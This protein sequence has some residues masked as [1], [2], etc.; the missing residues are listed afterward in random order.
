MMTASGMNEHSI[1]NM[2]F[3]VRIVKSASDLQKVAELRQKAYARHI[4]EFAKR[5]AVPNLK[6]LPLTY[7]YCWLNPKITQGKDK[8]LGQ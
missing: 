7:L 5:L 6:T 4:P 8:P 1:E 2:P 3:S